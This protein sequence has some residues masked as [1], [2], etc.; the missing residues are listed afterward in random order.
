MFGLELEGALGWFC[1]F[2]GKGKVPLLEGKLC[3]VGL[4]SSFLNLNL[5]WSSTLCARERTSSRVG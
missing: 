3:G 2:E 5:F 1:G 4:R